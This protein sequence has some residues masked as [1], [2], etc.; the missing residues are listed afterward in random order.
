MCSGTWK[1]HF[2]N[3]CFLNH[4]TAFFRC[5]RAPSTM[6]NN[7][8]KILAI[9][10]VKSHAKELLQ[11]KTKISM[12]NQVIFMFFKRWFFCLLAAKTKTAL[13]CVLNDGSSFESTV[14]IR[15]V[16]R[17]VFLSVLFVAGRFLL[18]VLCWT[19]PVPMD[20]C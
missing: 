18:L 14:I 5:F 2:E 12:C 13:N 11:S 7:S 20:T 4:L 8:L 9:L 10:A 17:N 3:L 1:V 19:A 16:C 15:C 6:L